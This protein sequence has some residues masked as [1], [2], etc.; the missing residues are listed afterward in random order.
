MLSSGLWVAFGHAAQ[1]LLRFGGNLALTR[2][3][4]PE[5]FG[6]MAIVQAVMTGL[7]LVSDVGITPSI[8]RHARG[9]SPSFLNTAWT[10][11][12]MRGLLIFLSVLLLSMPLGSFYGDPLLAR[13]LPAVGLTALIDGLASTNIG[14]ANRRMQLAVVTLIDVGSYAFGLVATIAWAQ[15]DCSVWALVWGG[16]IGA[17][18]RVLAS[19]LLVPGTRNSFAWDP[20]AIRS[21]KRFGRWVLIGSAATF[22]AGEGNRLVV[23][24]F[25]GPELM[26]YFAIAMTLNLAFMQLLSA[27]SDKV[28][29]PAYAEVHQTDPQ[30]LNRALRRSRLVQIAPSWLLSVSFVYLG[31]DLIRLLYDAR[32]ASSGWMLQTLALGPLAG[33]LIRSYGGVLWAKGLAS[34]NALLTSLQV[35]VQLVAVVGG[36][37]LAGVSGVLLAFPS[38]TWVMYAVHAY[39]YK[40]LN[41]WQPEVDLPVLLLSSWVTYSHLAGLLHQAA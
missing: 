5:A 21:L 14:L 18:A 15:A 10:L 13:L 16:L 8:V 23:A 9:D 39:A 2:L 33:V 12:V 17:V 29:F 3:L 7:K 32:Y 38:T 28:F 31:G 26:A 1:Q 6:L 11:Q 30:R 27:L 37:R 34:T 25:L 24:K 22:L 4:F 40:R 36:Y 20:A 35:A 19:H 41:L